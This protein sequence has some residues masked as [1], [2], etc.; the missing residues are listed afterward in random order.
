VNYGPERGGAF[1]YWTFRKLHK[2]PPQVYLAA[3]GGTYRGVIPS[4]AV[5]YFNLDNDKDGVLDSGS[6]ATDGQWYNGATPDI[7]YGGAI[8]LFGD[9][10]VDRIRK[11]DW[12]KNKDG[13]W[14]NESTT[15]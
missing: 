12:V 13:L 9:M 11:M 3:D 6:T 1:W 2:I 14:G 15:Y 4:P 10:H 7:H 5:W 8:Y